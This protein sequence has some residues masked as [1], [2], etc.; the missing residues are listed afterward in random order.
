MTDFCTGHNQISETLRTAPELTRKD[1][2]ILFF[3]TIPA[4]LFAFGDTFSDATWLRIY[5]SLFHL[6]ILVIACFGVGKPKSLSL[7][8]VFLFAC[9]L[10]LI[11]LGF[12]RYDLFLCV[13]N[14]AV[15]PS[16]TALSMLTLSGVSQRNPITPDGIWESLIRSL[17]GLFESIPLP[18]RQLFRRG[19]D[20]FLQSAI[21]TLSLCFC[22]VIL[23][24]VLALL[25]SAD[26]VFSDRISAAAR[27]A[28]NI[29]ASPS[30]FRL[31]L[32]LVATLVIFSWMMTLRL[33]GSQVNEFSLPEIP[34]AFPSM[35]LPMLNIVYALFVYIQF[36]NL[37]GGAET[38]A[39]IGGYAEYARTGFFQLVAVAFIN[40]CM[41]A[42]SLHS[43][44]NAWIRIMELLLILQTGVILFSAFW[45]MRLYIAAFGL[46][47]LRIMTL[48]GMLLISALLILTTI[49][50]FRRRFPAF[51][52]GFVCALILWIGLNT[53]DIDRII[54]E[55]NVSHYLSG[56]L[57]EIDIP[58]LRTLAPSAQSIVN[59]FERRN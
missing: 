57:E 33:P 1:W 37:F 49:S 18:F 16:L 28:D 55:Y 32:M 15:I 6:A 20:K 3:S 10:T 7:S 45:R 14:C 31:A 29:L 19:G 17:R 46:T 2:L 56:E 4:A 25:S 27:Y 44:R 34:A 39:M 59:E 52:A 13:A 22:T 23:I 9:D 26:A 50:L 12:F 54:A 43:H 38:A 5:T 53:I 42:I 11:I 41:L 36:S 51:A 8:S 58:Y 47:E 30:A 24:V 40:L 21:V 35:L 48:W